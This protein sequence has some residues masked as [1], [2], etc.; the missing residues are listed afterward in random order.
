MMFK[1]RFLPGI[2]DGSVT[3]S[4]RYWKRPQVVVGNFYRI[5]NIGHIEVTGVRQA[6]PGGIRQ[7]DAVA[8]G[9]ESRK[10]LT[11]YLAE[12]EASDRTLYRV[13]F[14]YAGLREDQLPDRTA[15]SDAAEVEKLLKA[16]DLRDKNSK[17][18]PWTR[19]T[20]KLVGRQ[21]GKSSAILAEKLGRDRA[22][23]KT[24]M[25]KLKKLGLTESLGV[26][27]R[28]SVKGESLLPKL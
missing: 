12:F 25:R 18:G 16:L 26:G 5:Q 23:L 14:R 17:V 15:V 20:L 2:V 28:L 4:Y 27:Y 11:D 24:D 7:A 10:A 13:D 1:Q 22:E 9:F 19:A 6:K 8:S 3:C 21:P